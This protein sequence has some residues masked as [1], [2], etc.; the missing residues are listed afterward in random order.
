MGE[1]L[2]LTTRDDVLEQADEFIKA[3]KHYKPATEDE[4]RVLSC[5]RIELQEEVADAKQRV[6]EAAVEKRVANATNGHV[7]QRSYVQRCNRSFS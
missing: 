6:A 3:L 2:P 7:S 4:A 5:Q 1:P